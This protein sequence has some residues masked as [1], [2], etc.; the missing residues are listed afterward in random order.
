MDMVRWREL[1]EK[2]GQ[3]FKSLNSN[4]RSSSVSLTTVLISVIVCPRSLVASEI[5]AF[6]VLMAG[7]TFASL[8][9]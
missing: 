1:D 3:W 2:Y 4:I 9:V 8:V 6:L 5:L 7:L